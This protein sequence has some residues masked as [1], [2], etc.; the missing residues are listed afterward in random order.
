MPSV[1]ILE[2]SPENISLHSVTVDSQLGLSGALRAWA[3]TTR[4]GTFGP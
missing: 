4:T 1:T 2:C 3:S